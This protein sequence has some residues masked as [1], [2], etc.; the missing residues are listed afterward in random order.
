MGC[1]RA[2]LSYDT[3]LARD[4]ALGEE[5]LLMPTTK[6]LQELIVAVHFEAPIPL[7]VVDLGNWVDS[8]SDDFPIMQQLPNL[9]QVSLPAPGMPPQIQFQMF[10]TPPLPRML[11]RSSDGRY[12]VQLK[13]VRFA[14]GWHITEPVGEAA[15]YDGFESHKV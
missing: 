2:G 3:L 11:L 14:F 7:A 5:W 6:N 4:Y 13:N 9:P 10:Q 1:F 15:Q 12:S 8:F